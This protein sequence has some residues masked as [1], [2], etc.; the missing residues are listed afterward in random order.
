[1]KRTRFACSPALAA[2][3][4][5]MAAT[6]PPASAQLEENLSAYLGAN[7]EGYLKP[8]QEA[9]G[10]ALNSNFFTTAAVPAQGLHL[11]VDVKAMSV[12]FADGDDTFRAA[13]AGDFSPAQTVDAPTVVGPTGAVTV[14]GDGGTQYVFPGGFDLSSF[15]L[16]VPQLTV[17]SVAGT[18]AVLRYFSVNTGDTEIGDV[19]FVGIGLRHSLSQ[20]LVLPPVDLSASV[21]YQNLSVGEDLLDATAWSFGIQASR[22]LGTLVPYAGL[23]YDRISMHA[24]YTAEVGAES[25][26]V[27]LDLSSAGSLHA[28]VG[29]EWSMGPIHLN[30]SG[31]LAQRSGVS[32]GVGVGL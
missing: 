21:V 1:M 3:V 27:D 32:A 13:T 24:K 17:G 23:S 29:L 15:T 2:W 22:S 6:A 25:E 4:V 7:A 26:Q 28:T 30:M 11:R 14:E 8:L 19:S 5:L 10:Q 16:A 31:E 20:H 18:E 12:L 9:F